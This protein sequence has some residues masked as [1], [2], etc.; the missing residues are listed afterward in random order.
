LIP[1]HALLSRIRWDPVFGRGKWEVAYL[2]RMRSGFVR[3]PLSAMQMATDNSFAFEV[4]DDEGV[5]H[6]IPY[7]RVR[8]VW[9]DGRLYWVRTTTRLPKKLVKPRPIRRAAVQEPRMRR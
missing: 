9:R 8:Q 4:T 2:D 5:T 7:H 6:S 3:V 1:I